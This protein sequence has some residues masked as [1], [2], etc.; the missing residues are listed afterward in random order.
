MWALYFGSEAGANV[1]GEEAARRRHRPPLSLPPL[2]PDA[3]KGGG[4]GVR[5]G[6]K[7]QGHARQ[8]RGG[9]ERIPDGSGG[10][11]GAIGVGGRTGEGVGV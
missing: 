6:G 5:S 8:G 9:E 7:A 4:R 10:T 2:R 1:R 3:P 11:N